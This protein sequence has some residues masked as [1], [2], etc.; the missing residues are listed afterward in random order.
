MADKI[1][2]VDD[3]ATMRSSI[4]FFLEENGYETVIA[5]DGVDGL[6]KLSDNE[7]K[8]IITD[9]NMPNMNGI[10]FIGH[11]RKDAKY[12]FL[13]II[14]LTTESQEDMLNK[15]RAAGAT[16]WIVKPFSNEK[17]IA[18]IKKLL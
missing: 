2:V 11:V 13:P 16:G 18:V 15:G 14:V 7:V 5:E 10:E 8:M 4:T 12:K 3:S 1:L 6:K 9:I 17:M